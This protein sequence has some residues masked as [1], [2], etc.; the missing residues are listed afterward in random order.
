MI[1]TPSRRLRREVA[2]AE[3]PAPVGGWPVW[4]ATS[5]AKGHVGYRPVC[6]VRERRSGKGGG[7]VGPIEGG[8]R[9]GNTRPSAREMRTVFFGQAEGRSHVWPSRTDTGE[10]TKLLV[11]RERQ[12]G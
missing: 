9:P 12:C 1:L 5:L 3:S 7:I 4:G 6:I 8:K 2:V 11:L 10:T